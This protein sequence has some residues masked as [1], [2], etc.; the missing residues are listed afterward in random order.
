MARWQRGQ[1][2]IEG[3]LARLPA[4]PVDQLGEIGDDGGERR[5]NV[6]RILGTRPENGMHPSQEPFTVLAR[7]AEQFGDDGARQRPGEF[8]EQL[9]VPARGERADQVIGGPLD[10]RPC[11]LDPPGSE[12]LADQPP[13]RAGPR[14]RPPHPDFP[15]RQPSL[16]R[17]PGYWS[18]SGADR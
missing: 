14:Y 16:G 17:R 5:R 4:L 11:R 2:D 9:S 10:H 7:Y 8:R 6:L 18:G 3:L 13:S 15:R 12:D 1:A